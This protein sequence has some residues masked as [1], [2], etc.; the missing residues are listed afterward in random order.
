M[1]LSILLNIQQLEEGVRED[2]EKVK[3]NTDENRGINSEIHMYLTH[4]CTCS[5]L[6]DNVRGLERREGK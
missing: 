5:H 1:L 2:G 6:F 3:G 4:F